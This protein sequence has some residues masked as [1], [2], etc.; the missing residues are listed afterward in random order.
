MASE[1]IFNLWAIYDSSSGFV[2][3]LSGKAYSAT[4]SDTEKLNILRSLAA[5]DYITA[6]RYKVPDRF[7]VHYTDGTTQTG[8][9]YLNVVHDP[10]AQL[11]EEMFKNLENDLPSLPN[12]SD[13]DANEIKQVLPTD[14]LCITTILYENTNGNIRPIISDE[15]R[16]WVAQQE[17]LR[18]L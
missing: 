17:Q 5:T 9:A 8:V 12:F 3:A 11:F 13:S 10:N 15:D 7:A 18:G 6:K 16:E 14:P 1:L 4:G 2:Y